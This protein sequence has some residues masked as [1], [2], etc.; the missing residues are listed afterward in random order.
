MGLGSARTFLVFVISSP[1]SVE[2]EEDVSTSCVHDEDVEEDDV[3]DN[4]GSFLD[5]LPIKIPKV[6]FRPLKYNIKEMH[7]ASIYSLNQSELP[8]KS[9]LDDVEL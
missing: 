1:V 4:S 7:F 3:K 9:P 8:D 6:K 5:W 2:F